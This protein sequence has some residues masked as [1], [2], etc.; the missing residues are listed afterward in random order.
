[1]ENLEAGHRK[2]KPLKKLA[3]GL[4]A[5][6][7]AFGSFAGLAS[8]DIGIATAYAYV[9]PQSLFTFNSETGEII[10]Y[11]GIETEVAIPS[12]I[13]ETTVT[14]IG[15]GAFSEKNLT[16]VTIPNTVTKIDDGAFYKNKLTSIEI[17]D[18]VTLIGQYAFTDNQLESVVIPGSVKTIDEEAFSFNQLTSVTFSDGVDRIGP[19]SFIN[20]SLKEIVIPSSV[21][22]IERQ[23]FFQNS[24]ESVTVMNPDAYIESDA[25]IHNQET[26]SDLKIISYKY[27]TDGYPS[28]AY[29]VADSNQYTFEEIASNDNDDNQ[30]GDDQSV[31]FV[32]DAESGTI[33][34]Y[35]GTETDIVIPETIGG[36]TVRAIG[37]E[38]FKKKGL[39]SVTIPDTV[40]TIGDSAFYTNNL[41]NV[42]IPNSVTSIGE[43]AFQSNKLESVVLSNSI[44]SIGYWAFAM[45]PLSNV[46]IPESVTLIDDGAFYY[47]KITSITIP[48]SVTRIGRSAFL[49]NPLSSVVIPSSVTI[50]DPYAFFNNNLT[51]V[52]IPDSVEQIGDHAFASNSLSEV[53]IRGAN[54]QI[55][56]TAFDSN[57]TDP[58][59]LTIKSYEYRNGED[60]SYAKLLANKMGYTFIA[61]NDNQGEDDGQGG[62]ESDNQGSNGDQGG[63]DNSG[64][65]NT[66]PAQPVTE[67]ITVDVE[68]G[69]LGE[70]VV[71]QTVI[72][73]T[74]DK[75][76][77]QDKVTLTPESTQAALRSILDAGKSLA[78][79]VIPDEKDEV[80]Q[81]DFLLPAG[82]SKQI[83]E[84]NVDLEIYTEN[85]RIQIPASSLDG[86]EDDVYF[87]LVPIRDESE[88]TEVEERARVEQAVVSITQGQDVQ[89]IARPMTIETNLQSRPV[90]LILPLIDV[91]VPTVPAERDAFLAELAV[92]I[93]H[94]DGDK[95]LVIPQVV[96]YKPGVYGLQISVNK[97]ST[98]TILKMEGSMQAESGH[99]ASYI[100]GFVDGTFKPEKSITR[101]EIAAILARNL[102][103]EAEA[104]AD[105]SF[106]DVSDSYWAAQEIEYVKSLG[107]MVGDDQGNFRP[108]AP[109]TRGEMAAI[110]ARYKELDT[111]GITASSFGDV[112]VGYWGT[113]AIEAAKA[114][115]ILDGYEDGTFKP[116]DQLTRAEAVKI[117][118]RLF[119]RGPLH[120]LTQPS[121]PD[122][123]TT[124]WAYEEIEEASQAHDYTNL[125][126]GG[127][128]IR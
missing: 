73:R 15:A 77:V 125:P 64:S 124:H 61:I 36:T 81:I 91:E 19:F 22:S 122:V 14:V 63:S 4:L 51:S 29:T 90:T 112:E 128:N 111:T 95:E 11:L 60:F 37:N 86:M 75:G 120:G 33:T 92:F 44:T 96:E 34:G 38:A 66:T 107:L 87:R 7:L 79:V 1:V 76:V 3:A 117:V 13:G 121:W 39:T 88:R 50:I 40:E 101:A 127:E 72:T 30:G 99:H 118:N 113:A 62:S 6:P 26:P 82:S 17:P 65:T 109:I 47:N 74:R 20:N 97:F 102:G 93:E 18:S 84:S 9:D 100:N 80:S 114:A 56:D 55:D 70:A 83:I 5:I 45:N 89:V 104:A 115:G 106:P 103:F 105:S 21:T 10:N 67:Q 24:L 12:Q 69:K 16:S 110:A 25:F 2:R 126:E 68:T 108:N 119:N 54:T 78:R 31:A 27:R 32:F 46:V 58:S 35:T 49:G 52:E 116:F 98:F 123:P 71:N 8:Q 53:V 48:D 43:H 94:T 23:A 57:T 41:A 85:V 28:Y 42:T 59:L